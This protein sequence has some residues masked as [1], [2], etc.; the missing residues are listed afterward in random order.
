[1]KK[2]K[3]LKLLL[4]I[5]I[6]AIIGLISFNASSDRDNAFETV[7]HL[8]IFYSLFKELNLFYVDDIVPGDIIKTGIDAMLKS[9]DPYTVYVPESNMEELRIMTTGKYGG[10]GALIRKKGDYVVIAQPYQD[11]PADKAGLIAGDVIIEIDGNSVKDKNVSDVS[12][13][14]KGSPG[15]QVK[16]TIERPGTNKSI[17]K[18]IIREDIKLDAVPYYGILENNIGYI[19]LNNFTNTAGLDVKNAL[20]ELKREHKIESIVIDLRGNPGGLLV[21]A[22]KI[23]NLFVD[24][25]QEIV[26]TRGKVAQWDNVYRAISEPLDKNIKV[27]TL[28]NRGS[29]SAS[30]IVSGAL[31]DLDRGVV[32]G[33]QTFGKGLVQTTRDLAYNGMLK[34]T[35]AKY[36]IPSGRCIQ[37]LDY[38][39]KDEDGRAVRVPDSLLVEFKTLNGR[40]VY[41]GGGIIPD[42]KIDESILSSI[43]ISL[44]MK[45]LIFDFATEFKIENPEIKNPEEFIFT[46]EFYQKFVNFL[47]DKDFDYETR[48]DAKFRELVEIA[49]NDKYFER[50]EDEFESLRL[51]LSHDKD[52]D[53][54]VF[55]EEITELLSQEIIVRYFYEKGGIIFSLRTDPEIAKAIEILSNEQEY[56]R[57]IKG[58]K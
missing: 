43:S 41:E 31:Q 13:L 10:I 17:N 55:K 12:E 53:L 42:I 8:D 23:V 40:S 11:R 57:I 6:F 46:D 4:V 1:M 47:K 30:E 21:E 19:A 27:I 5:P 33:Q 32:I 48:T 29:A 25:G 38:S 15:S 18:T 52:K 24:K 9:L 3:K 58:K 45:N 37:A 49:K 22:V 28:V 51:K 44:L 54:Q 35:T 20:T 36:Y 26:S 2:I 16:V 50:A 34:V 14:L 39:H 7:K 56:Q